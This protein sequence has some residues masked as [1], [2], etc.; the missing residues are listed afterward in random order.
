MS[1]QAAGRQELGPEEHRHIWSFVAD[2]EHSESGM[3]VCRVCGTM[4]F[5]L[6]GEVEMQTASELNIRHDGEESD[7]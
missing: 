2:E 1:D 7:L 5:P 6:P 3:F 4:R